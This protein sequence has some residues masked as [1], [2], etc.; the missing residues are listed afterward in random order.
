MVEKDN[1][2]NWFWILLIAIIAA[3]A[4]FGALVT[5]KLL[6]S[7]APQIEK[8]NAGTAQALEQDTTQQQPAAEPKKSE[9]DDGS[10]FVIQEINLD[11]WRKLG[12]STE[13]EELTE[14]QAPAAEVSSASAAQQ[15][16]PNSAAQQ[17]QP[18]PAEP[19]DD[20]SYT[21]EDMTEDQPAAAIPQKTAPAAK[22]KP[23]PVQ[24]SKA[25]E[26][27]N[28]TYLQGMADCAKSNA[29][30]CSWQ[31]VSQGVKRRYWWQDPLGFVERI[32]YTQEGKTLNRTLS[33]VEGTVVYYQGTFAELYFEHGLL[34]KIRTFPY[35]NPNL[36][37][38]FVIDKTGKL[39]TCLCGVPTKNC[40]GRSMLYREGGHRKYCELFPLD[41]DFC[42]K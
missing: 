12:K 18:A 2:L 21:L 20:F 15:A 41:A 6:R 9:P 7:A 33:T 26:P 24:K 35:D 40:C 4:V 11:A 23:A 38:W 10:T 31:N 29:F 42:A 37:D 22:P 17:N 3:L 8:A 39:A 5:W 13:K 1:G 30:P 27:S 25:K 34:T 36:R 16:L 32:T 28:Q 19:T 14:G